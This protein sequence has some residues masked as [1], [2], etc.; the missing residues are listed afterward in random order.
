MCSII[1]IVDK[2]FAVGLLS[3]VT[4][5]VIVIWVAIGVSL[6]TMY[7]LTQTIQDQQTNIGPKIGT[8]NLKPGN[9]TGN[10]QKTQNS[11][12]SGNLQTNYVSDNSL[13]NDTGNEEPGKDNPTNEEPGKDKPANEKPSTGSGNKYLVNNFVLNFVNFT[14]DITNPQNRVTGPGFFE[15]K[16]NPAANH[17]NVLQNGTFSHSNGTFSINNNLDFSPVVDQI[18]YI[19]VYTH[20]PEQNNR[21]DKDN[22]TYNP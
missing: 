2:I 20:Y 1:Y 14:A 12:D 9:D 22:H 7:P 8:G 3:K 15:I 16:T 6:A 11:T 5:S 13:N 18:Y 10:L 21:V 4:I 19:L 17:K